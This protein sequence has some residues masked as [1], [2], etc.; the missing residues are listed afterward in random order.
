[1]FRKTANMYK[2]TIIDKR[3]EE[4]TIESFTVPKDSLTI[5]LIPINAL[6]WYRWIPLLPMGE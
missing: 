5:R 1:V 2:R 6:V 4:L 3:L